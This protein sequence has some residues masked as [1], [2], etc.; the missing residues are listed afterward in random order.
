MD[1]DIG[2]RQLLLGEDGLPSPWT[3]RADIRYIRKLG[4]GAYGS[5][6]E[7]EWKTNGR[8]FP[9]PHRYAVKRISVGAFL[10]NNPWNLKDK[11]SIEVKIKEE[12]HL[13]SRV[14][15]TKDAGQYVVKIHD[16]W[17][18]EGHGRSEVSSAGNSFDSEEVYSGTIPDG[19]LSPFK[20]FFI[21]MD[22]CET[23]LGSWLVKERDKID[24]IMIRTET[25]DNFNYNIE[26]INEQ[27]KDPKSRQD[28]RRL[29]SQRLKLISQAEKKEA[30]LTK[31]VNA[32]NVISP[33]RSDKR[34]S[35]NGKQQGTK[36]ETSF[37]YPSERQRAWEQTFGMTLFDVYGQLLL[38]LDFLHVDCGIVHR[39]LHPGNI[40]LTGMNLNCP[41]VKLTDFGLSK[42]EHQQQDH[43]TDEQLL[44]ME[45]L[46]ITDEKKDNNGEM[47]AALGCP[48]Y[49]S[50]DRKLDCRSDIFSAALVFLKM[51]FAD[52]SPVDFDDIRREGRFPEWIR[53]SPLFKQL[54][55]QRVHDRMLDPALELRFSAW[56]AFKHVCTEWLDLLDGTKRRSIR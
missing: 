13:M 49:R 8:I 52:V 55:V 50:P 38:C 31:S 21:L 23:D 10:Q 32:N 15:G 2:E 42:R 40:L 37:T 20:C 30:G 17:E 22:L 27:L 41:T 48:Q 44:S 54:V 39:D 26:C 47:S 3:R 11:A 12:I 16:S 53:E 1:S 51:W 45:S 24:L 4:E 6:F 34:R 56:E 18:E 28:K 7:A 33:N 46:L 36:I 14:S 5:V 35:K 19:N 29:E 43:K 9:H 25:R